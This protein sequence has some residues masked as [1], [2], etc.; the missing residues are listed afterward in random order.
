MAHV[1]DRDAHPAEVQLEM[2]G[3]PPTPIH[4]DVAL[5]AADVRAEIAEVLRKARRAPS[6]PWDPSD[7]QHLRNIFSRMAA[8]LPLGEAAE[9]HREFDAEL[10]RL[11][12]AQAS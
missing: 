1:A 12:A 8:Q 3:A 5:D 11:T 2:F 9:L 10:A 4:P 7:V 6:E